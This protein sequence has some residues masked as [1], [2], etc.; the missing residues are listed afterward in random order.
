MSIEDVLAKL[1]KKTAARVQ[2]ASEVKMVR[3]PYKSLGLTA[4]TGGWVEGHVHLLYGPKSSGKSTQIYQTIADRQEAD[5]EFTAGVIDAEGT[6]DP[7]FTAKLGVDNDRVLIS[8]SKSFEQA[9]NVG[10]E[11]LQAGV[12][13]LVVDSISVL[14]PMGFLDDGDLKGADGMKQLGLRAKSTGIMLNSLSYANQE[15]HA[16]IFIVSHG[17][18]KLN[19]MGAS[20]S[21]DGGTAMEHSAT[22]I[23]R[24]TASAS[25]R[26]Q[27]EGDVYQN[28]QVFK[29]PIGR[30]VNFFVEKNKA[31]AA[32]GVGEYNMYYAGNF[33]GID[34]VSET[35]K[36]ASKYNFIEKG[37]AWFTVNGRKMQGE[38]AVVDYLNSDL[39]YFEDLQSKVLS[40]VG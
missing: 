20:L 6:Y 34:T 37:G 33:M 10:V 1:D 18:L 28:G 40:V 22:Q 24:L 19:A 32:S 5:P 9:Q 15:T 16:G 35:V 4:E 27:I 21:Y 39:D 23:I 7:D 30:E 31:G 38:K 25:A 29:K 14:I 2:K 13:L 8:H 26:Q 12:R 17:K 36:L 11:F 3:H